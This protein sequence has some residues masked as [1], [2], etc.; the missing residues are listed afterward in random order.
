MIAVIFGDTELALLLA[1][2]VAWGVACA[3]WERRRCESG[4]LSAVVPWLM[5]TG[6]VVFPMGC[7]S[8]IEHMTGTRDPLPLL[9]VLVI[10]AVLLVAWWL[11]ALLGLLLFRWILRV[12]GA[13][14]SV[15]GAE[16]AGPVGPEDGSE[17]LGDDPRGKSGGSD[18]RPS[19]RPFNSAS[20]LRLVPHLVWLAGA[21][22]VLVAF[23]RYSGASM[24]YQDPTPELLAI[25]R[26]QIESAKLLAIAG[27]LF[28]EGGVSWVI[29][30]RSSR[31]A[32]VTT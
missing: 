15:R 5:S 11:P 17:L 16:G 13:D 9:A 10:G 18:S 24:P 29:I 25:Q 21:L 20:V 23:G 7:V 2:P 31:S 32:C 19:P 4:P 3:F 30:R 14:R 8:T 27:A 6:A 26:G 28:L 1:W 22:A 12:R